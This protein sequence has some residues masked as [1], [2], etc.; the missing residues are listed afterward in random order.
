MWKLS[1]LSL[2]IL[3]SNRLRPKWKSGDPEIEYLFI[4]RKTIIRGGTPN[5]PDGYY[6]VIVENQCAGTLEFHVVSRIYFEL[7]IRF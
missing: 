5:L 7:E 2:G 3:K 6:A 1:H 4:K